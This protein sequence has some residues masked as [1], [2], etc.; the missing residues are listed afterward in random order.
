M[1]GVAW[2]SVIGAAALAGCSLLPARA[3]PDGESVRWT[4]A[5]WNHSRQDY[6]LTFET[7]TISVFACEGRAHI[8]EAK[9]PFNARLGPWMLDLVCRIARRSSSTRTTFRSRRVASA[10]T[11]SSPR[12]V[13]RPPPRTAPPWRTPSWTDRRASPV[14]R[15]RPH[16]SSDPYATVGFSPRGALRSGKEPRPPVAFTSRKALSAKPAR[17]GTP[18]TD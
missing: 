9:A 17:V 12:M 2:L 15:P 7:S 16:S 13:R 11:S 10:T 1:K 4:I 6:M 3:V 5:V 18:H 8:V 14:R